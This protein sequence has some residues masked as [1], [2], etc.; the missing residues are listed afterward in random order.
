MHLVR[1]ALICACAGAMVVGAYFAG[2]FT[3]GLLV[4]GARAM[5]PSPVPI[6]TEI[7]ERVATN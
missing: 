3:A 4:V 5:A 1:R 7:A 6:S 2:S